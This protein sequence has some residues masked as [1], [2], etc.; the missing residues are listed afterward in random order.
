MTKILVARPMKAE[1][2][3]KL[4]T[5]EPKSAHV[6]TEDIVNSIANAMYF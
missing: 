2:V 6:L 3:V 4:L 5:A 1:E